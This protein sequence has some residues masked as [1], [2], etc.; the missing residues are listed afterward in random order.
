MQVSGGG[1]ERTAAEG[2]GSGGT[3]GPGMGGSSK[4]S[5]QRAQRGWIPADSSC[6]G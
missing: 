4:D 1:T 2:G 3:F 6:L 5:E